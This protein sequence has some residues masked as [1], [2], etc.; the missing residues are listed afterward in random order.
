MPVLTVNTIKSL[1]AKGH[2]YRKMDAGHSGFGVKVSPKGQISFI[3]RYKNA[4]GKDIPMLLGYYPET[5]LSAAREEWR[6]WR[7]VYDSGRDPKLIRDEGLAQEEA[8]RKAAE[9]HR[10]QEAMQGSIKE[11]IDAYIGN[12]KAQGKR[13]WKD[14][15]N[16]LNPNVYQHI[17]EATKA[18]DVT[19][20]NI[21]A[22]LAEI[23]KRDAL[24]LANRVRAYLSAAFTFGIEWDNDPN[25]H[26]EALRF[27]ISINPV[28]DVP[29]PLKSEKPRERALLEPEVKQVWDCIG[30]G[31]FHPKTIA[32]IRLL[33][34]LGGQRVEDVLGIHKQ[35]V[36]LTNRL[37]TFRDTKNGTTHV[38][39]F[40]DVAEP[41]LRER[42][43]D[44]NAAGALFG[45]IKG[46]HNALIDS[47]TLAK[48]I[49]KLCN[50]IE[51]EQFQAK[52]IR[53]TVKTLMGF[54]GI[55]KEDRD[56][57][58]NHALT[59]VSS[60]HYDRYDYLAE[61]RQVMAVWDEFLKAILAGEAQTNVVQ[62]RAMSK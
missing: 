55:R 61:K 18:K 12:L 2:A 56:R 57:F 58:Q 47:T 37:V 34:A 36:D 20:A 22:V 44:T 42:M 8:D 31:T 39:P 53:R 50:R 51:L 14:V 5:S 21:R 62:L 27:G 7:A 41:I 45:K 38:V 6:T 30:Y 35:D 13:S 60:R 43:Q 48:A 15:T 19:Q 29:K 25:R 46:D 4:E 59:D 23:I 54:A 10:K 3:F 11:L 9:E 26:F 40:G 24:I 17:P 32:A 28:R 52:D 49:T 33:L 1:K 16:C